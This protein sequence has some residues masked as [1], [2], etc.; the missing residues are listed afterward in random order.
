MKNSHNCL[1]YYDQTGSSVSNYNISVKTILRILNALRG[2]TNRRLWMMIPYTSGLEVIFSPSSCKCVLYRF[3]SQ[4]KFNRWNHISAADSYILCGKGLFVV[5]FVNCKLSKFSAECCQ[6]LWVF[7]I[8][9]IYFGKIIG[10]TW[11]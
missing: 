1:Y 5:T 11:L 7:R 10:L 3:F 9:N 4:C 8:F 6:Q 2:K